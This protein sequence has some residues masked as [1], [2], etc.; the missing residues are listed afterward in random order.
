[1]TAQNPR[2]LLGGIEAGGTKFVCAIASHPDQPIEIERF[3]TSQPR[4]TM[5]RVGDF[6]RRAAREHGTLAALGVGTFGPACVKPGAASYG[7]I[8]NTPKAGWGNHDLLG[9]L[10]RLLPADLPIAFETDVIAAAV[11]E[12]VH[13]AAQGT[14]HVAYVTVGTGIGGGLLISG[15]PLHGR[16]HPEIGHMFVGTAPSALRESETS[17]ACPFHDSC[18]EG[19]A[20]GPAVEKRWGA[21]GRDLPAGHPAWILEAEFLAMGLVN[22]TAAW[23]PDILVLGGGVIRKDGLLE[24]VRDNFER[25]AAGYWELPPL[26]QYIV[27]PA[28]GQRAGITGALTLASR[29]TSS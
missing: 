15:R 26:D 7:K 27:A 12:A 17:G 28:L 24:S 25:F 16:L 6:F 20:S 9:A 5:A 18:L 11:G 19:L 13:G 8:L 2:R 29:M 1:M 21:A 22:L 23:S 14:E 4:D 3:P 10:R